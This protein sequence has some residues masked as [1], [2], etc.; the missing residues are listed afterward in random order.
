[1]NTEL[2]VDDKSMMS[3][4]TGAKKSTTHGS[5]RL[6]TL[7]GKSSGVKASTWDEELARA[8]TA[9]SSARRR[10]VAINRLQMLFIVN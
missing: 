2:I 4:L 1:M 9:R 6:I 3:F 8:K 10:P 7:S 5:L